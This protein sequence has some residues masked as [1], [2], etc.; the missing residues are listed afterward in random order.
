[1]IWLALILTTWNGISWQEYFAGNVIQLQAKPV[2][3]VFVTEPVRDRL[4]EL[5]CTFS[6]SGDETYIYR[7]QNVWNNCPL[8]VNVRFFFSSQTNTYDVPFAGTHPQD[9]WWSATST[10]IRN[11]T[12]TIA[13]VV[14]PDKWSNALGCWGTNCLDGFNQCV[15]NAKRVGIAFGGGCFY[16]VGIALTNGTATITIQ[17]F[18][19]NPV[20]QKQEQVSD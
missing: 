13:A 12:Q 11:G 19:I 4:Y 2:Y 18:R 20:V 1:M 8:P 7:G 9:Y 10:Q 17:D 15:L 3:S 5:T 6:I 16:D 14:T